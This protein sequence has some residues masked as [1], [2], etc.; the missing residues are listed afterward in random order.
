MKMRNNTCIETTAENK[1]SQRRLMSIVSVN[2][3]IFNV[4][5]IA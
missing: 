5:K 4:A 2:R 3:E 1:L